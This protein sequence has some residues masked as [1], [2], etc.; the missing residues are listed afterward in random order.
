MYIPYPALIYGIEGVM[1]MKY[2]DFVRVITDRVKMGGKFAV[3]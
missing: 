1:D 3:S 2:T